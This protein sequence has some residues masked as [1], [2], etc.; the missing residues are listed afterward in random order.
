MTTLVFGADH[1]GVLLKELLIKQ[2]TAAAI[3]Q[4]EDVGT[5]TLERTDYPLYVYRVVQALQADPRKK[6]VLL[7]GSGIG[8]AIAANRFKG[9]YA[10]CVWSAAAAQAAKAD[11]NINIL[12]LP[13]DFIEQEEA[14]RA[15]QIWLTTPFK[16]DRYRRRLELLEEFAAK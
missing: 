15:L 11:D 7:C 16:E 3:A 8:M 13:V 12:I 6:G 10:G 4:I 9:M 14:W 1:R 5:H 2:C